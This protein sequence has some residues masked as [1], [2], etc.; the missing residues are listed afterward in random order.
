[1]QL[2]LIVIVVVICTVC[3][4]DCYPTYFEGLVDATNAIYHALAWLYQ[5]GR[6]FV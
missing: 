5:A 6:Y 3:G 1:M 4:V 2:H